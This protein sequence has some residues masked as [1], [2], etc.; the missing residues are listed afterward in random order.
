[1]HITVL[2]YRNDTYIKVMEPQKSNVP[3]IG[4][5]REVKTKFQMILITPQQ[6]TVNFY[7]KLHIFA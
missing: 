7:K 6:A 3:Q 4:K 5:E 1:M 2:N